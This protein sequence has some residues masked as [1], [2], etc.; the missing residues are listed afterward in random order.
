MD[1]DGCL[2]VTVGGCNRLELLGDM[3]QLCVE[4]FL[5]YVGILMYDMV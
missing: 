3:R 5:T 2:I 4:W 1:N